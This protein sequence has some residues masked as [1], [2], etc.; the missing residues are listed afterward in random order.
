MGKKSLPVLR[1]E[2][3]PETFS[4]QV[5]FFPKELLFN[6]SCGNR[7][8]EEE[9]EVLRKKNRWRVEREK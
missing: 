9:K 6:V 8:K 3:E 4:C 1:G 7:E 5:Y 2:D